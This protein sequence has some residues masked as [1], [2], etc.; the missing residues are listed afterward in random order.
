MLLKV[1]WTRPSCAVCFHRVGWGFPNRDTI[2]QR[3]RYL[4][5]LR[6]EDSTI[7]LPH[8]TGKS[9]CGGRRISENQGNSGVSFPAGCLRLHL[10][11]SEFKFYIADIDPP[12]LSRFSPPGGNLCVATCWLPREQF[13]ERCGVR[14]IC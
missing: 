3:K 14:Q 7:P 13:A 4:L 6:G 10:S 12:S 8:A 2:F 1:S 5:C 11:S 9:I